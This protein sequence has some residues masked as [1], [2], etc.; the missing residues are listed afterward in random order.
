MHTS[1]WSKL[2]CALSG[3]SGA[4]LQVGA[5]AGRSLEALLL[6]ESTVTDRWQIRCEVEHGAARGVYF[7][8][9]VAVPAY[10]AACERVQV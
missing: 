10:R 4:V 2:I 7:H 1:S 3:S 5:N 6:S 8:C 9:L